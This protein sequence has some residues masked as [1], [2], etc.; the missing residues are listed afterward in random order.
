MD[1]RIENVLSK[2]E[3]LG[4]DTFKISSD[5]V[6][7]TDPYQLKGQ[8]EPADLILITHAH[9]DHLSMDDINKIK[10]DSTV[11]VG[12][13]DCRDDYPDI[14]TISPGETK[15]FM[16]VKIKAVPAY[17]VDK[18]FHPE[19]NEWVGYI[20]EVEGVSIYLAGDTDIISEMED[21]ECD[22]ALLPVSGTYVMTA[23]EAI[24]AAEKINPEVAVPMHYGAIVGDE[25]DAVKFKKGLEGKIKVHIFE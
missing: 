3:W 12:T 16:G 9:Y 19:E 21:Y 22:I 25:N 2:M 24:K 10:K 18:D 4:H 13:P 1:N 15:E 23:E 6:I 17:N 14:K 11:V 5:V 8:L 7:Y 20:F